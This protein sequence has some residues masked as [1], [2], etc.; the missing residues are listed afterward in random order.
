M[1][2]KRLELNQV[3]LVPMT[4]EHVDSLW[5][6][7]HEDIWAYMPMDIKEKE[8]MR[9]LVKEALEER[10]AGLEFPFVIYDQRE[11]RV[12]GS[13]RYLNI[14]KEH[15]HLEI[16]WTW[17]HPSVWRTKVNTQCKFL[18]LRYAFEEWGAVR[19]QLKT[20]GRNRRS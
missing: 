19:V 9:K 10:R 15:K 20:D 6:A 4:E 2:I 3:L 8:D 5:E 17:H 7:S 16:G 13:T 12:V 14:S 1:D 18:L 11:N